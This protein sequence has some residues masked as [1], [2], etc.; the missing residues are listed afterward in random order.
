MKTSILKNLAL[1]CALS[2]GAMLHGQDHDSSIRFLLG[3]N[4]H[5]VNPQSNQVI[6][7]YEGDY[8]A[9]EMAVNSI[10]NALFTSELLSSDLKVALVQYAPQSDLDNLSYVEMMNT[11]EVSLPE[12]RFFSPQVIP[13]TS[14]AEPLLFSFLNEIVIQLYEGDESSIAHLLEPLT[15][16]ESIK[17]L[18]YT[19]NEYLVT[20]SERNVVKSLNFIDELSQSENV[21]Y[22]FLNYITNTVKTSSNDPYFSS[23]WNLSNQGSPV[24][25]PGEDINIECAWDAVANHFGGL[26]GLSKVQVAII[27]E[28]VAPNPD[29][30]D[31][32]MDYNTGIVPGF[33]SVT[34]AFGP[35]AG[36][37]VGGQ[38]HGTRVASVVGASTGNG[39]GIAGVGNPESQMFGSAASLINIQPINCFSG[40]SLLTG[41]SL[42]QA[43]N[44]A[45][46]NGAQI[47]VISLN[48]GTGFCFFQNPS[49]D[50][51]I[52]NAIGT[53]IM[54]FN[55]S[56]NFGECQMQYPANLPEI[57]SV[58]G[59][60]ACGEKWNQP[61]SIPG[62]SHPIPLSCNNQTP[63][64]HVSCNA[65]P[66]LW[67]TG[68]S[69]G[70]GLDFVAP[71]VMVPVLNGVS[72]T[73]ILES[74][75]SFAAPQAAGV[76]ALLMAMDPNQGRDDYFEAI[77]MTCDKVGP[78]NYGQANPVGN[79]QLGGW[80]EE[81]GYG[82][83]NACAAVNY[84]IARHLRKASEVSNTSVANVYPSLMDSKLMVEVGEEDILFE[85][86]G[87]DG[88]IVLQEHLLAHTNHRLSTVNALPP[89]M[90]FAM[91][92]TKT[93]NAISMRLMKN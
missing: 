16:I 20:I 11:M 60:D 4:I 57:Y 14:E 45:A 24:G 84:F 25:T 54:V 29:L 13:Q 92:Q 31:A 67:A 82:R 79:H 65:D 1:I 69:F 73:P 47:I 9:F 6:I 17:L 78:Y 85:I 26:H 59:S 62:A 5:H 22:C 35:G 77:A 50:Q 37:P 61:W 15:E 36:A 80:S 23:Q 48:C 70:P 87:L 90:Y 66:F 76:A 27:D 28:G 56:G 39:I 10:E 40:S 38:G 64:A 88:K 30:D 83:I 12:I 49:V 75:T 91:I 42:S 19:E 55:S 81:M 8:A 68:A 46:D 52:N 93:G 7:G 63:I 53:G 32:L 18:P 21:E 33:N 3:E 43:F 2:F 44:F 86:C 74:G 51:A 34:G 41:T 89:G 58:G 72:T 71:S